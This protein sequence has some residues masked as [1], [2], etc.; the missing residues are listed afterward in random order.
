MK[1]LSFVAA[2]LLLLLLP[3]LAS[4]ITLAWNPSPTPGVT[5]NLYR[6]TGTGPFVIVTN[7]AQ[8]TV[9]IS[10]LPAL[11]SFYVTAAT[12]INPTN[13]SLPSNTATTPPLASAVQQVSLTF[14]SVALPPPPPPPPP[15]ATN[16]GTR[17]FTNSTPITIP[18]S[19]ASTPYPS[20]ITVNGLSG[21]LTNVSVTIFGFGHTCPNDVDILLVGPSGDKAMIM[22]DVGASIDVNN[23]TFT[24]SDLSTTTLPSATILINNMVY[25]P[26]DYAP[27]EVLPAPAPA[28]PYTSALSVFTN[29]VYNGVWSLYVFDDGPGDLGSLARGWSLTLNTK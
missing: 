6:A 18:D 25:Q 19:G 17:S 29:K 24:L 5:Y 2:L 7:T 11:S 20:T 4:P 15:P 26:T 12:S 3:A 14:G 22:S 27:T 16:T 9:T 8:T 28:G 10:M 13:E 21:T 1:R 23:I